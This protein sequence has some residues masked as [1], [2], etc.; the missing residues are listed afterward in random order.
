MARA[1]LVD[2][3]LEY[4]THGPERGPPVLLIMGIEQGGVGRPQTHLDALAAEGL[5]TVRY[6]ARDTG[7]STHFDHY[8][9]PAIQE[10]M[11]QAAQGNLHPAY[12]LEDMAQDAARLLDA[13]ALSPAHVVGV[14]M[15]GIV[16]QLL[17]AHFP[18]HV[19]SFTSIMSTTGEPDLPRARPEA[20]MALLKRPQG[21][22]RAA[23]VAHGVQARRALAGPGFKVPDAFWADLTG[24]A[25]DRDYSP[26]GFARHLMAVSA[27][28]PRVEVLQAIRAPTLVIHGEDDPLIPPECGRRTA[29]RIPGARLELVR[30]MGHDLAPPLAPRLA[31]SITAHVRAV[32]AA[33]KSTGVRR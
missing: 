32:E 27:A 13:L 29:A 4:A 6:D 15:G 3:E 25:Y 18:E 1:R 21:R 28:P 23:V 24:K 19:A 22:D 31:A 7:L 2:V 20:L 17:A 9:P 33:Q 12:R 30:G 10:I 16:G 11:R 8:L 5:F 26:A 14:S